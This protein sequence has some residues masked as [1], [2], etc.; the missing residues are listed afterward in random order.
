[1]NAMMIARCGLVLGLALAACGCA[2]SDS[3]STKELV[4]LTR[5][6]CVNTTT[7]RA[8][9]DEALQAAGLTV[10]YAV[11]DAGT[12]ADSDPRGG[13]GTPTILYK[14]RDL[15]GLPEPSV[16]HDPPT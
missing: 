16:P 13:Y 15:F 14:N 7:M 5:E 8:R 12:L 11:I 1:M 2:R 4:F 9:L 6:G 3:I 10:D